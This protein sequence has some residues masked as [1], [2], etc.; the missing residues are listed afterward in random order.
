L[1]RQQAQ[2]G[3]KSKK[4]PENRHDLPITNRNNNSLMAIPCDL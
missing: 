2:E 4:I 1:T 3:F